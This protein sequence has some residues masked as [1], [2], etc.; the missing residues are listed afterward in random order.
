MSGML[1]R[2]CR[3]VLLSLTS[4]LDAVAAAAADLGQ[5][6]LGSLQPSQG[7]LSF[8]GSWYSLLS[9]A[10]LVAHNLFEYLRPYCSSDAEQE[11]LAASV[12]TCTGA[13]CTACSCGG[14]GSQRSPARRLAAAYW[15]LQMTACAWPLTPL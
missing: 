5:P 11:Q 9:G 2:P 15:K 10:A 1:P 13:I 14:N 6:G 4:G 3:D 7:P 8:M 12:A